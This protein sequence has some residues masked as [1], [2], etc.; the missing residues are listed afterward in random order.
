MFMNWF[1]PYND[2]KAVNVPRS[3]STYNRNQYG[4]LKSIETRNWNDS[5]KFGGENSGSSGTDIAFG[6]LTFFVVL[7]I[8]LSIFFKLNYTMP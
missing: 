6:S 5:Y 7:G 8:A 1:A 2:S 3:Q 4:D